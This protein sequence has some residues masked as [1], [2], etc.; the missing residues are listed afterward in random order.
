MHLS[1]NLSFSASV[2]I[3]IICVLYINVHVHVPLCTAYYT[4]SFTMEDSRHV[5]Y[6]FLCSNHDVCKEQ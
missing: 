5:L 6:L 4:C 1:H 3:I 2:D